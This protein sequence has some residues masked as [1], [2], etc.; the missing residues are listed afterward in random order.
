MAS[1]ITGYNDCIT[2]FCQLTA[3]RYTFLNL[4]HSCCGNKYTIYAYDLPGYDE[5]GSLQQLKF[6]ANQDRPL[7][8]NAY[9]K[10]IYNDKKGVTDWQRVPRAEVP[11]AALAK[12]D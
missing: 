5:K 10:V 11:K 3:N 2:R 1:D 8:M 7:K 6:N 4:A 9:L 12:L